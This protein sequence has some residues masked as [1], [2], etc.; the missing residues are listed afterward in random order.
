MDAESKTAFVVQT[1]ICNRVNLAAIHLIAFKEAKTTIKEAG[2]MVVVAIKEMALAHT[3]ETQATRTKADIAVHGT[4]MDQISI[5]LEGQDLIIMGVTIATTEAAEEMEAG[6]NRTKGTPTTGVLAEGTN[7]AITWSA[8][9]ATSENRPTTT[10][11]ET[12]VVALETKQGVKIAAIP[13]SAIFGRIF[14]S[15]NDIGNKMAAM[16]QGTADTVP[17]STIQDHPMVVYQRIHP[18]V[19][20]DRASE[21]THWNPQLSVIDSPNNSYID[22]DF[23]QRLFHIH[24]SHTTKGHLG[25]KK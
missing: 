17:G 19:S 4:R 16:V 9:E 13:E 2:T 5:S 6:S 22:R 23:P 3:H 7:T 15:A 18:G 25:G 12:T 10:T 21:D 20:D 8:T 24:L 1:E 14:K 11:I